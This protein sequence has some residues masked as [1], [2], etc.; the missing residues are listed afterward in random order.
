MPGK[1]QSPR[2]M[3]G[4]SSGFAG[5]GRKSSGYVGEIIGLCRKR[6]RGPWVMPGRSTGYA[7]KGKESS[8]YAGEIIRLYQKKER[9]PWVMPGRSTGYALLFI[10]MYERILGKLPFGRFLAAKLFQRSCTSFLFW[11]TPASC[12]VALDRT[13]LNFPKQRK[14]VSLKTVVGSVALIV[15]IAWSRPNSC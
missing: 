9:G 12:T 6:E 14:I 15:P 2:V 4:K 11:A 13:C 1:G 10:K 8:G 7:G 3:P 5:K